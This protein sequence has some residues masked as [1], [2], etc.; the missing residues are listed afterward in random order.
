MTEGVEPIVQD[1]FVLGQ[2]IETLRAYS[3][4]NHDPASRTFSIHRLVQVVIQNALTRGK[5][6]MDAACSEKN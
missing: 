3:L 5:N 1:L 6:G 2:A 4:V